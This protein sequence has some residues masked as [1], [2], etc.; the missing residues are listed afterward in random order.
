MPEENSTNR[1]A[2]EMS[3]DE[4]LAKAARVAAEPGQA[5]TPQKAQDAPWPPPG[6]YAPAND[7]KP[8]SDGAAQAEPPKDDK[9]DA[10]RH[11]AHKEQRKKEAADKASAFSGDLPPGKAIILCQDSAGKTVAAQLYPNEHVILASARDDLTKLADHDV[12]LL[13]SIGEAGVDFIGKTG[14][15]LAKVGIVACYFDVGALAAMTP[16]APN[17]PRAAPTGWDMMRAIDEWG[18][19][20]NLL[21][22][23]QLAYMV[24]PAGFAIGEHMIGL[25]WPVIPIN[26]D[27]KLPSAR[28]WQYAEDRLGF[29]RAYWM[30][31]SSIG[32]VGGHCSGFGFET[33]PVY[34]ILLDV[35]FPDP[36]AAAAA[37][38]CMPDAPIRTGRPPKFLLDVKVKATDAYSCDIKWVN[39]GGDTICMQVIGHSRH[40]DRGPKQALIWGW[41]AG[42]G[43]MY[44]W[45]PD[46]TGR[47]FF[48]MKPDDCPF[49]ELDDLLTRMDTALGA[50]G[51]VR[52]TPTK[53]HKAGPRGDA[54]GEKRK[55]SGGAVPEAEPED[56]LG[57][58]TDAEADQ[59]RVWASKLVSE[60]CAKL[61]GM[62]A[63]SRRGELIFEYAN[64][65]SI[66]PLIPI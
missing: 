46:S 34:N 45:E 38:T 57:P 35:D 11:R 48:D 17:V 10:E 32:V 43:R 20:Q 41:H 61:A 40:A 6:P 18:G 15:A 9:A 16:G 47:M 4:L 49:I 62:T 13:S 2:S 14:L 27:T 5:E 22:A 24:F 31:G 12:I 37:R 54:T 3:F 8:A 28:G 59:L 44:S 60:M 33:G 7:D 51:W 29:L 66:R 56:A 42:A 19:T 50:L 1:D 26:G 39:K 36:D 63:G 25:G 58:I 52:K 21:G 55:A 23:M 65:D 64:S 30:H 53:A